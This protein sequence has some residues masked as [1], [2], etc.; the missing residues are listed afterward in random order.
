[1]TSDQSGERS[2][3]G[4][5]T[6]NPD[7]SGF[8]ESDRAFMRRA[9]EL[10][11]RGFG[12]VEPNP[13]VGCVLTADGV[14]V[15]EGWHKKF[16]Q[17]HAEVEALRSQTDSRPSRGGNYTAYVTLE[18][19]CHHG[20]TPPCTGALLSAG[21]ERV[22]I[23]TADPFPKVDGGGIAELR[24]S[25]VD[26]LVG[27]LRQEC[28]DLVA[29]FRK[30]VTTGMP[31]T[32]AKWAMT[33]DG[34][35]A[36]AGGQSQWITGEKARAEV[37]RRRGLL[38]GILVGH[39]TLRSDDPLLTVRSVTGSD[40]APRHPTRMVVATQPIDFR[41]RLFQSPDDGPVCVFVDASVAERARRGKPEHVEMA[42]IEGL[43]S[44]SGLTRLLK[45]C[46]SRAQTRLM[47]E[48][49]SKVLGAFFDADCIDQ[50]EVYLGNV[51][52]GGD[53][54][55]RPVGGQGITAIRDASRWRIFEQLALDNDR[56]LVYRR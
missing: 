1:M 34:A 37:H 14:V 5:S 49:G 53:A 9:L 26:V 46:G 43:S 19:C 39:G 17:P 33:L 51:I 41:R 54:A 50:C 16:G 30:L 36:T 32:I 29:P 28:E 18:P 6:A 44:K 40:P 38:D 48:G 47:V 56:L 25:G 42:C 10:A 45:H 35:I 31:W 4:G 2:S 23:G 7:A 12:H 52:F 11:R 20:K 55:R 15:G 21:I 8:S 22:V 27:C 3:T 24:R 13:P